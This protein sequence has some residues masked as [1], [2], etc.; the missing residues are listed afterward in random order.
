MGMTVPWELFLQKQISNIS[1]I[2]SASLFNTEASVL[3][4]TDPQWIQ[5]I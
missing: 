2:F 3:V 4:M 5:S 1:G